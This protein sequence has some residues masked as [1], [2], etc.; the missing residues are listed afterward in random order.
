MKQ[1]IYLK[2][3][4]AGIQFARYGGSCGRWIP[5]QTFRTPGQV[6]AQYSELEGA[7]FHNCK[8]CQLKQNIK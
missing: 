8:D 6:L 1:D 2:T 5:H 3:F 7:S 4:T